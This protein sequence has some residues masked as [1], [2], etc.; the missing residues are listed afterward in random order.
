MQM[1]TS[2]GPSP[3]SRMT[4]TCTTWLIS[5]SCWTLWTGSLTTCVTV[6]KGQVCEETQQQEVLWSFLFYSHIII[7]PYYKVPSLISS[8]ITVDSIQDPR[9]KATLDAK[10]HPVGLLSTWASFT[11]SYV[12]KLCNEKVGQFQSFSLH[13]IHPK[14]VI[15]S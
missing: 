6:S 9:E 13:I 8:I 11:P 10:N 12:E 5:P 14:S 2:W 1:R 15:S 3:L 4:F 7:F